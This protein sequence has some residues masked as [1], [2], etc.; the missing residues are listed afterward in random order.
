MFPITRSGTMFGEYPRARGRET[1]PSSLRGLLDGE[2]NGCLL[3]DFA[4]NVLCFS[5]ILIT[6]TVCA[7]DET[8]VFPR[9]GLLLPSTC[10]NLMRE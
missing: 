8:R 5:I 4:G 6:W 2:S 7:L 9:G 1:L 3:N 10:M